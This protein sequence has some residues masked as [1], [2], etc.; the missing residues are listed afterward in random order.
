VSEVQIG[1]DGWLFLTGG[2]NQALRYYTDPNYFTDEHRDRWIDLLRRRLTTL[3]SRN[4][5]FLH[6][7]AP[8]KLS[9][10]PEKFAQPLPAFNCHPIRPVTEQ[11]D[12]LG[13]PPV[14][15]NPAPAMF[16][17]P[18]KDR[19]YLKTDTHW[20]LY[21]GLLVLQSVL[22]RLGVKRA[23]TLK[24]RHF[25]R[26]SFARDLG[27]K[28]EPPVREESIS[29]PPLATVRRTHANLIAAKFEQNL[30]AGLPVVHR[31]VNVTFQNDDPSALDEVVV[32]FGD[33]FMDFQ[34]SNTTYL[35]AESFR[36]VHFI[37]S[38][39]IDYSYVG[40]VD[41]TLVITEIAERFMI[42]VPDDQFD[43]NAEESQRAR[44]WGSSR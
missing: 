29:V 24:G 20:T 14:L 11:W 27:H 41:A 8:D 4:V 12:E 2:S 5:R 17:D 38:A 43:L 6:I 22:D 23:A 35:F 15:I 30:K 42:T 13:L 9:I 37:W 7:F 19:F 44:E 1:L 3:S 16:A 31:G 21:A 34:P 39:N 10:Y 26:H 36:E 28:L 40:R 18:A 33:S 32:I 25:L